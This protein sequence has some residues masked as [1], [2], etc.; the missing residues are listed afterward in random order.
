MFPQNSAPKYGDRKSYQFPIGSRSLALR[1]IERDIEEGADYVMVKPGIFY[2]DIIREV[3]SKYSHIP[4][5]VY[6]V[7]GECCGT[8][9]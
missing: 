5:A 8:I 2:L 4:I 1:G 7:S 3:A 9:C 6:Q